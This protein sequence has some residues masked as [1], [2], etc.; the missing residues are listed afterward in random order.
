MP[1]NFVDQIFKF[2]TCLLETMA[3]GRRLGRGHLQKSS[4]LQLDMSVVSVF[5][6][7]LLRGCCTCL[8]INFDVIKM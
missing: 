2:N 1:C 7:V 6:G 4:T 3:V 8:I 5:A